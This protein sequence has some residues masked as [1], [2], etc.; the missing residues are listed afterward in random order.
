MGKTI[1][2]IIILLLHNSEILEGKIK[3]S[4]LSNSF[5]VITEDINSY[6][7]SVCKTDSNHVC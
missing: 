2:I 3:N 4:S 1:I 6:I 5:G 7:S